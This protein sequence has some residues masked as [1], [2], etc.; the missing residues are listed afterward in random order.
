MVVL[1]LLVSLLGGL[2][3]H[4]EAATEPVKQLIDAHGA[5]GT[6]EAEAAAASAVGVVEG[7]ALAAVVPL[8]QQALQAIAEMCLDARPAE[9]AAAFD[10]LQKL[11]LAAEGAGLGTAEGLSWLLEEL[12]YGL[13]RR[14]AAVTRAEVRFNPILIRF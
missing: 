4:A 11:V 5:D 2:A 9:R 7:A 14:I 13:L 3:A 1:R 10:E 6:E 8:A 12:L